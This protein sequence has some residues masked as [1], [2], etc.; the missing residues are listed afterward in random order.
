[1]YKCLFS[2]FGRVVCL[3]FL[4]C[5]THFGNSNF[6]RVVAEFSTAIIPRLT[7]CFVLSARV[8][9]CY[10]FW[11]MLCWRFA[12]CSE[13]FFFFPSFLAFFYAVFPLL[14]FWPLL[15]CPTILLLLLVFLVFPC[16][17]A[18]YAICAC[19]GGTWAPLTHTI[20]PHMICGSHVPTST[21]LSINLPPHTLAKIMS[22]ATI[23]TSFCLVLRLLGANTPPY[24]H[25]NAHPP[26]WVPPYPFMP[27]RTYMYFLG[28]FPVH[29]WPGII[30]Y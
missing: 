30:P 14:A 9:F 28:K 13:F 18:S 11:D 6:N 17:Y 20:F 22:C 5:L 25:P 4:F 1:M 26:S 23:C 29:T 15:Q 16:A 10:R 21:S 27:V 2:L 24:T 12:S 3:F 7:Q 19:M 8:F